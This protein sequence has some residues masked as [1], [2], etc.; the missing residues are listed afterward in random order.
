MKIRSLCRD[1]PVPWS[2]GM[3]GN[4]PDEFF[5]PGA[6]RARTEYLNQT[7]QTT[8]GHL[9][10]TFCCLARP[11]GFEPVTPAF[12]GHGYEKNKTL[13]FQL[14]TALYNCILYHLLTIIC[15]YLSAD[16]G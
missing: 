4:G 8:K 6:C 16:V 12:G 13:Y 3:C 15:L 5:E 9:K 2:T 14:N 10:V 1:A 11:T 7:Q